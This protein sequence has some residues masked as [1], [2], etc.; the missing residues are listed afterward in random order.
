MANKLQEFLEILRPICW[1]EHQEG[2]NAKQS[3]IG[4]RPPLV[5]KLLWR[6]PLRRKSRQNGVHRRRTSTRPWLFRPDHAQSIFYKNCIFKVKKKSEECYMAVLESAPNNYSILS[7]QLN[8]LL[9]DFNLISSFSGMAWCKVLVLLLA[10]SFSRGEDEWVWDKKPTNEDQIAEPSTLNSQ[11]VL[12]RNSL[13]AQPAKEELATFDILLPDGTSETLTAGQDV[14]IIVVDEQ[15]AA[16][17]REAKTVVTEV[18]VAAIA[19]PRD[20][21]AEPRFIKKAMCDLG[22]GSD[23]GKHSYG[24]GY[25]PSPGINPA[26]IGYVQPVQINPVGGPVLSVPLSHP[27][28]GGYQ[29]PSY[30]PPAP[31]YPAP[32]YHPPPMAQYHTPTYMPPVADYS[33]HKHDH[34]HTHSHTY[35]DNS[36]GYES[37]YSG[38]RYGKALSDSPASH[39]NRVGDSLP[40]IPPIPYEDCTCVARQLCD[41]LDVVGRTSEIDNFIDARNKNTDQLIFSTATEKDKSRNKRQSQFRITN[42]S[43]FYFLNQKRHNGHSMLSSQSNRCGLGQVCCRS[44]GRSLTVSSSTCGRRN[45]QGLLGR[46]KNLNFEHGDTEFGEYPWQAAILKSENGEGVYVCG[47]AL[48]DEQHLLTATHC[49]K[50]LS[51]SVMRIR[52]GE[53][54]VHNENEFYPHVENRVSGVYNH[55][56]YY[57]GKLY[58]DISVI[59]MATPVNFN[60]Y[61]HIAPVCLPDSFAD[62]VGQRCFTTGWG[63]DAFGSQGTF[64]QV[65]KEVDVPVADHFQCES[66]LRRTRLGSSFKLHEG[67]LCAGGEAGKDACKGDGGGPLVC[68]GRDGA[69]Q[70]AGLVSWGVGC[71]EPGVPGVYVKVNHYLQWIRSIT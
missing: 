68:Q 58:N 64:Q 17:G 57:S 14:S 66:T 54:D 3:W 63:K 37:S 43:I 23:C 27:L 9:I 60:S 22:F 59:R 34:T 46:V 31:S 47:A 29:P 8:M 65:L 19:G 52:L 6:I 16:D 10:F 33:H 20:G 24:G 7:V 36:G 55:P 15:A 38:N 49:V 51:P 13:T 53:W 1:G 25:H 30:P 35:H 11:Q 70:L 56:E 18:D 2:E 39:I 50:D 26:D 61:P 4:G 71:G 42:Q 44:P 5:N 48:I 67:M 62:F 45:S 12:P 41:V 40:I 28:A 69:M 32:A 21:Q